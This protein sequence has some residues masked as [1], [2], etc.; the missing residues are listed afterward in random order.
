MLLHIQL[1]CSVNITFMCTGKPKYSC[2]SILSWSETEP[3]VSPGC[4]CFASK[5][6]T[7]RVSVPGENSQRG[8]EE[9]TQR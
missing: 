8:R 5:S 1:H 3:S 9:G 6:H 7:T 4:A 2:S